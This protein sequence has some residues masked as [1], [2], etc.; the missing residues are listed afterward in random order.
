MSNAEDTSQ[1]QDPD[2]V[3]G[4][5]ESGGFVKGLGAGYRFAVRRSRLVG[6]KEYLGTGNWFAYFPARLPDEKDRERAAEKLVQIEE[7]KNFEIQSSNVNSI[8]LKL[9][10]R[11]SGGHV[12]FRTA[13]QGEIKVNVNSMTDGNLLT[14]FVKALQQFA[15]GKLNLMKK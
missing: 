5:F 11:W 4:V 6:K 10:G 3:V 14:S 12:A 13:D 7:N 8:E 2:E 9:P 1:P 15:P